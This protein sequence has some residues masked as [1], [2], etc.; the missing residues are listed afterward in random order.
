[1]ELTKSKES[2]FSYIGE[3]PIT[4]AFPHHDFTDEMLHIAKTI[5]F[6]TRNT[7][8]NS[9]R[10]SLKSYT[11]IEEVNQSIKHA[12]AEK[13]SLVFSGHSVHLSNDNYVEG[14]EPIPYEILEEIIILTKKHQKSFDICTFSQASVKEYVLKNGSYDDTNYN[15]NEN[16]LLYLE[17]KG[18]TIKQ[19][20][21][22]L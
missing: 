14:Y 19:L 1:M 21:K 9:I 8:V 20:N 3:C 5:Y 2:I 11:K 18:I 7:L 13:K 22:I 17:S 16:Q 10:F 12:V 15:L 6:E 4:F